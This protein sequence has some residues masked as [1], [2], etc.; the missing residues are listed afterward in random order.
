MTESR[1]EQAMARLD[2]AM[3][4]IAKARTDAAG[5]ASDPA[6]SARVMALVNNHEKLRE[7]VADTLGELDALIEELE[8]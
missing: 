5:K 7:E 1:I 6:G 3:A 2:A 4:R 8:G